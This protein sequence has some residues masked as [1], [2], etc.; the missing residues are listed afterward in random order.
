MNSNWN[1]SSEMLNLGQNWRFFVLCDFEIWCMTLKNNRAPLLCCFKLC[2]SFHNHWCIQTN[3]TVLKHSIRVK[4][5]DL[6]SCLTLKFDGSPRKT[7]GY[8]FYVDSSFM[9]HFIAIGEFKLKLQSGNGQLRP[10]SVIFLSPVTLKFDAW[11]WKT[12]GHLSYVVSSF[13]HH[14][15]TIGVFKLMLQS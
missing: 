9:Y 14:F 1:Y 11:P 10:K 2:T 12:T 8:L 13:V 4:I 15:I 7:I 6:L 3:V 5:C